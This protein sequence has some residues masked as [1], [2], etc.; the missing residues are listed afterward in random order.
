MASVSELRD[1]PGRDARAV[2]AAQAHVSEAALGPD[3]V[4]AVALGN[5]AESGLGSSLQVLARMC[6]ELRI[7]AE[8]AATINLAKLQS[9]QRSLDVLAR[10][11]PHMQLVALK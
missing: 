2:R 5:A 6:D 3:Q 7:E 10:Y 8:C 4:A 1:Q 9:I 11:A